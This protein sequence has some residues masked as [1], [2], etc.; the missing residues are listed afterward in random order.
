MSH[1]VQQARSVRGRGVTC[2]AACGR[3]TA[4]LDRI[5]A[6]GWWSLAE[7]PQDTQV[8]PQRPATGRPPWSGQ[9]RPPTRVRPLAGEPAPITVAPLA[10]RLPAQCWRRRTLQEGRQG[11][12]LARMARVRVVAVREGWP[13]PEVWLSLR[14]H[15]MTGARKTYLGNAPA[16][17]PLATLVRLRGLRWPIATC[18]EDGKQYLGRGDD[19]V[20][21]WRGWHHHR[22]LV[23]LAHCFLVR[24]RLRL[25][26]RAGPDPAPG[27]GAAARGPAQAGLCCPDGTGPGRLLAAAQPGG[28]CRSSEATNR[29]AQSVE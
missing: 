17:T 5:A 28:V 23:I 14:R 24:L 12:R 4:L 13:G 29:P 22:T 1:A 3:E 7:V 20:R 6:V 2:D 10:A 8:W 27:A 16:H 18:V 11:P 19:A 26:K 21:R 25:K 15:P 9:G